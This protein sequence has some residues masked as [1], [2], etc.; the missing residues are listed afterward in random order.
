VAGQAPPEEKPGELRIRSAGR[1]EVRVGER[2]PVKLGPRESME[3]KLP[4][5]RYVVGAE[6][7]FAKLKRDY[8]VEVASGQTND[9]VVDFS[10]TAREALAQRG[11][12]AEPKAM[13]DAVGRNQADLVRLFLDSGLV[14]DQK[15]GEERPLLLVAA[16]R[17]HRESLQALLEATPDLDA[18]DPLGRT[19]AMWAALRGH[20]DVVG[21]LV[22]QGAD[23]N[24][25][26]RI[27]KDTALMLAT[28]W[29]HTGVVKVLTGS[30]MAQTRRSGVVGTI[31]GKGGLD[32][33]GTN[34]LG[35]TA[36]M[37]AARH[38]HTDIARA[39]VEAGAKVD[40]R[41]ELQRTAAMLARGEGHEA[42][43]AYLESL[44]ARTK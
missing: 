2:A 26:D 36:V 16:D 42:T 7:G 38:G 18:T 3:L 14:A 41:D 30:G 8:D 13:L 24:H 43:A 23:L 25:K 4:P 12:T 6:S 40:R 1:C 31:F 9:L 29:G 15:D 22:A 11:V 34:R 5:G 21:D 19:A 35:W 39:L 20:A 28:A 44:A 10:A 17:G 37:Y 32:V 27:L 33:D